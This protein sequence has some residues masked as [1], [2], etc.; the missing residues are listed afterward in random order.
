MFSLVASNRAFNQ[1][2]F[3][4]Y[5]MLAR[6]SLDQRDRLLRLACVLTCLEILV[7]IASLVTSTLGQGG[8]GD[9]TAMATSPLYRLSAWLMILH[10]LLE[11]SVYAILAWMLAADNGLFAVSGFLWVLL[12]LGSSAVALFMELELMPTT[13]HGLQMAEPFGI[14]YGTIDSLL[15]LIGAFAILPANGFFAFA[16]LRY[17][18]SRRIVPLVLFMG[19]P[20]GLARLFIP[21]EPAPR[22]QALGDWLV[23][24][25]V[26]VKQLT[27]LWWFATLLRP[28]EATPAAIRGQVLAH[29]VAN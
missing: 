7:M 1:L 25:F 21:P 11:A 5:S 4:S 24:T 3:A 9:A 29:P 10:N 12:G 8:V 26:I 19:I 14:G 17:P 23:P 16:T 18:Q 2:Q 28:A 22:E 27:L 6:Y 15:D 13:N 20:I